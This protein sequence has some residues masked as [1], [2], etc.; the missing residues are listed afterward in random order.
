MAP[1]KIFTKE[2]SS[3]KVDLQC[4]IEYELFCKKFLIDETMIHELVTK[5]NHGLEKKVKRFF[6]SVQKTPRQ[7][8]E[9]LKGVN[10]LAET[11]NELP[12]IILLSQKH[13]DNQKQLK[14]EHGIRRKEEF[15]N[16]N[17]RAFDQLLKEISIRAN[18]IE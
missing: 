5:N 7:R 16:D 14:Y 1:H 13:Y 10:L 17:F 4:P 9:Y 11:I 8:L 3:M 2:F 18:T 12:Q 6:K 15:R